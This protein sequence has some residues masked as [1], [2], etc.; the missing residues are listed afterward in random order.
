MGCGWRLVRLQFNHGN[1]RHDHNECYLPVINLHMTN[2]ALFY[3]D[4]YN[5]Q[6][7][8]N[9]WNFGVK[10]ELSMKWEA[11]AQP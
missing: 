8:V 6:T 2:S 9:A 4:N 11:T 7:S 10:P 1:K 5:S 3:H